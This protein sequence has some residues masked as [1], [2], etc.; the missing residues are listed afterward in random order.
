MV[1]SKVMALVSRYSM[2]ADKTHL[3]PSSHSI[4][5]PRKTASVNYY[6]IFRVIQR[7]DQKLGPL[8]AV[9]LVSLN[10]TS[11]S[12]SI[13]SI[14]TPRKI[15]SVNCCKTFRAIQR[16]DQK[17]L[18]FW[19]V[20]LLSPD[21][22]SPSPS[23]D[24]I[25]TPKKTASGNTCKNLSAIQRWDQKLWSF[26]ADTQFHPTRYP[27]HKVAIPYLPQ[28]KQ[29]LETPVNIWARS[30]GRIKSSS[31][32]EPILKFNRPHIVVSE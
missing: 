19:V 4:G 18:F 29:P 3:S 22:T 7:S 28:G 23:I 21:K 11:P 13:D 20:T 8:W 26:W 9:T 25:A 32:F 17:L 27:R 24:S 12:P 2:L 31:H 1:G 14:A 5:T 30:N 6:K 10:Q 16:S 15:A